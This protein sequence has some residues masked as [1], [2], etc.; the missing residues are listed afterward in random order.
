MDQLSNQV[1]HSFRPDHPTESDGHESSPKGPTSR[2][3]LNTKFVTWLMGLPEGWTSPAP[4]N[5]ADLET[6]SLR[7]REHLHSLCCLPA[8]GERNDAA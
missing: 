3:R 1:E 2:R 8:Q 5:S 4:I 7:S 6:W